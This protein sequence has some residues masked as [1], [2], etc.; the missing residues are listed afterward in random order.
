MVDGSLTG[1]LKPDP[2]SYR[3]V[4]DELGVEPAEA[5]FV[6]DLPR[7]VDGALAC[8]LRTVL[9]DLTDVEGSFAE[10]DRQAGLSVASRA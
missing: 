2:R 4:L 6:D 9:L 8:G 1:V 5:V 3:L 7:N 10:L